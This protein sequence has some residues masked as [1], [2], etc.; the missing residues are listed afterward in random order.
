MESVTRWIFIA[1]AGVLAWIY[2]PKLL[3]GGHDAVQPIGVGRTESAEHKFVGE[4]Q[5]CE[6]K[7]KHFKAQLSSQ[8]AA[9]VDYFITDDERYTEGG[10][11]IEVTTVPGSAPERFDLHFD[12]RALATTDK[13]S[14]AYDVFDWKVEPTTDGSCA[15]SYADDHVKL[16]KTFRAGEGLYELTT[17]ATIENLDDT[18]RVHRLG[19]ENTAWRTHQETDSHLGRQSPFTTEVACGS[20]AGKL[21]RK[22]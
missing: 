4:P 22:S 6:V 3:G 14:V 11:P 2:V 1:L 5:K 20:D 16:T 10:K 12:W 19:V 17:S 7:G 21:V 9:L 13:S 18:R 8:G 15:F